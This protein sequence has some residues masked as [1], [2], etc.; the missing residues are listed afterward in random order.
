MNFKADPL[1][2]VGDKPLPLPL[3]IVVKEPGDV[4]GVV[5]RGSVTADVQ[6]SG[7]LSA[8][9]VAIPS[10]PGRRCQERREGRNPLRTAAAEL[11]TAPVERLGIRPGQKNVLLEVILRDL[12][13]TLTDAD[14]N[15]LRDRIYQALHQGDR[16]EVLP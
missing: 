11:P 16:M 1:L 9:N 5:N 3:A 4:F 13:R 15:L 7:W 12:E 6:S 2:R 8:K 10:R 14:A